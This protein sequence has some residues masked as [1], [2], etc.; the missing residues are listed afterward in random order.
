[1]EYIIE[2]GKIDYNGIGRKINAVTI[3]VR[4][5]DGNLSICGSIWNSLHTDIVS[6]GQNI[7]EIAS[8][9]PHNERVQRVKEVWKRWHLNDL[10]AGS[11]KQEEYLKNNPITSS[12]PESHYE[13]TCKVLAKKGL[14]P[15]PDYICSGKPY[16]YGSAWLKEKLPLEIIKEVESKF[17]N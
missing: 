8:L 13:K 10:K 6:G 11:P 1:M 4:L 5:G 7:D 12:Y 15:D 14:N 2:L 3:E 16:E 17:L 9:F